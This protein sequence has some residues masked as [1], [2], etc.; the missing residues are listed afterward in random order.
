MFFNGPVSC[1]VHCQGD[2]I[3]AGAM[4]MAFL[5]DGRLYAGSAFYRHGKKQLLTIAINR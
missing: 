5:A 1:P 3:L 2:S 4:L